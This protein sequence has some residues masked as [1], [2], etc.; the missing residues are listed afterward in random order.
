M[1]VIA[2]AAAGAYAVQQRGAFVDNPRAV[3]LLIAA[4]GLALM[5]HVNNTQSPEMYQCPSVAKIVDAPPMEHESHKHQKHHEPQEVTEIKGNL[6]D[7]SK[8]ANLYEQVDDQQ[9]SLD[10]LVNTVDV[11]RDVQAAP[12]VTR[13]FMSYD[14]RGA[15]EVQLEGNCH[16]PFGMSSVVKN[17]CHNPNE[18]Q[19]SNVGLCSQ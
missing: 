8:F 10:F 11:A 12:S 1:L 3:Y 7:A 17:L 15:P 6:L 18:Q 19:S 14:L 16:V 9:H 5:Y 2:V 4:V 13:R